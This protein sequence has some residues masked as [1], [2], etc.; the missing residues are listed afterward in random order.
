MIVEKIIFKK[1]YIFVNVIKIFVENVKEIIKIIHKYLF[2]RNPIIVLNT[3][4]NICTIVRIV[5][6][7]YVMIV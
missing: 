6:K 3:K 7:I 2:Q 4:K 5:R 1:I